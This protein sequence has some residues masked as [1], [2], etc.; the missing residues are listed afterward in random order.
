MNLEQTLLAC[1]NGTLVH[2]VLDVLMAAIT[3]LAMPG[4]LLVP[5]AL[6]LTKRKQA[7]WALLATVVVSTLLSVGL[8]FAFDRLRPAAD[9]GHAR[10]AG[11]PPGLR[12]AGR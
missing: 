7:A 6:M 4:V 12:E 10:S 9:D 5:F 3:L 11:I 8:Q 1:F 2:P